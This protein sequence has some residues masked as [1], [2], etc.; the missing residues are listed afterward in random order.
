[1]MARM[2]RVNIRGGKKIK[3]LKP[4]GE[5]FYPCLY[6][7]LTKQGTS[8]MIVP[9]FRYNLGV[10]SIWLHLEYIMQ[11]KSSDRRLQQAS[12]K[13][14]LFPRYPRSRG[15]RNLTKGVSM[16]VSRSSLTLASAVAAAMTI[17][18]QPAG[19]TEQKAEN[20]KCYGI[21][22][23]GQNDCASSANNTCAGTAKMDY[24]K[25]AWKLVPNGTCE[26]TEVILKNGETRKGS[27]EPIKGMA[28]NP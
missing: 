9:L 24:D 15:S 11:K 4:E 14:I 19:A 22:K 21:A 12:G 25:R 26:T 27:L 10:I 6:A 8:L 13:P 20:V 23:A 17:A 5:S 1:M 3:I 18:S 28:Q 16:S 7:R 2:K